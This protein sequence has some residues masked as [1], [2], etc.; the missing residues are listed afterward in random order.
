MIEIRGQ[1]ID[2]LSNSL[3]VCELILH[4]FK[5]G[6]CELHSASLGP[7]S[8]E[9]FFPEIV[10]L[11]NPQF[12]HIALPTIALMPTANQPQSWHFILDVKNPVSGISG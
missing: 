2:G 9:T 10:G 1:G 11:S 12:P 6:H 7:V 8:T 4:S 3:T 5:R